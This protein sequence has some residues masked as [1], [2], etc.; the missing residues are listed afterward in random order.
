VS[1]FMTGGC[2]I[3]VTAERIGAN[4][5]DGKITVEAR[6]TRVLEPGSGHDVWIL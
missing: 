4:I 2:L 3:N 6:A 1:T 5:I